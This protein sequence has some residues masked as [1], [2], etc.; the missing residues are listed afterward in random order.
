MA[1]AEIAWALIVSTIGLGILGTIFRKWWRSCATKEDIEAAVAPLRADLRANAIRSARIELHLR[2][3]NE[4]LSDLGP[5][6]RWTPPD[7]G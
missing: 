2:R 5:P 7:G 6:P 3:I 4:T 1:E